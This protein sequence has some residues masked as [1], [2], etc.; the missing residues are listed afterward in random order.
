[1]A[2]D[3]HGVAVRAGERELLVATEEDARAANLQPQELADRWRVA[4]RDAIITAALERGS[5]GAE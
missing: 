4:I 5:A 1:M 3:R 2:L